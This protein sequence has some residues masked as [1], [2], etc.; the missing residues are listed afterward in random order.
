[1]HLLFV[2]GKRCNNPDDLCKALHES[3]VSYQNECDVGER[4]QTNCT[5]ADLQFRGITPGNGNCFFEAV[6][7][8]IERLSLPR[9]SPQELRATVTQF[10]L[11]NRMIQ[12][13]AII[14]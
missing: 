12:V 11:D 2:L 13:G 4:L 3:T 8:Q 6:S 1:M 9:V 10:L 7:S 5:A 14:N